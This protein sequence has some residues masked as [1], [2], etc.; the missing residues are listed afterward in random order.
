VYKT[1][2][3][4]IANKVAIEEGKKER[5]ERKKGEKELGVKKGEE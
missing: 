1:F 3:N 4:S 5:E 2:P